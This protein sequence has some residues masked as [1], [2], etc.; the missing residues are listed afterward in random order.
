[1][2]NPI[3]H[4]RSHPKRNSILTTAFLSAAITATLPLFKVRY[5]QVVDAPTQSTNF[6]HFADN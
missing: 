6:S 4:H 3:N 1:M 2:A 5:F